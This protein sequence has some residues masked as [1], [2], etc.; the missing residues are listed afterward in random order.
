MCLSNSPQIAHINSVLSDKNLDLKQLFD[1]DSNSVLNECNYILPEDVHEISNGLDLKIMH[2]N[3]R[4][5]PNKMDEF[6]MLIE[7]A[8]SNNSH[9]DIVLVCETFIN[10]FN[11]HQCAL[12]NYVLFEKHRS[13]KKGGGVAI[14]VHDSIRVEERNDLDIFIEGQIESLFVEIELNGKQMTVGELYRVPGSDLSSFFVSYDSLLRTLNNENKM[15]IIGTDQNL[16]FL[17][18]DTH[19]NT[20]K[21]LNMNL[22]SGLVPM[23]TR[24]TRITHS[25]C[26]LIDNIYTNVKLSVKPFVLISDISD[27]LPCCLFVARKKNDKTLIESRK[28]NDSNIANIKCSLSKINWDILDSLDIDDSYDFF[29][30]T[31]NKSL[32]ENAPKVI[33]KLSQKYII[34][35]PWMTSGLLKS[36]KIC[37]RLYKQQIG[38]NNSDDKRAKYLVYRNKYN[39]LKRIARKN[40]YSEQIRN[41]K[42]DSKKLWS[43]F[44]KV[45]GKTKNKLDLPSKIKDKN[46]IIISGSINIANEFCD[47]FSNIGSNLSSKIAAPNVSYNEY[48]DD[49]W[50]GNAFFLSPTDEQE[51]A[52][53]I[54]S[55]K[56]KNSSGYDGI[57]NVLIKKLTSEICYPLAIIFNKS[58][59]EGK[60]P[61][62]MKVADVLP[63]FKSK[64]KSVC[65]NYR[66]IS[67]LPVVSKVLERI[68][69]KRLYYF[70]Q[71]EHLLYN[72]QYGFRNKHS[73]INA[74]MEFVGKVLNGF[75]NEQY[76]LSVFLDLSK[77]FDTID[78]NILLNKLDRYGIRGQANNWFKSYLSER[79][80]QV[81]Y[82]D[83]VRSRLMTVNC[84][85]P[86]GSV[87]GP[88]LFIIYTNDIYKSVVGS[89]CIL[90]AD[91][92]TMFSIHK[93]I[94]TLVKIITKDMNILIDWFKANKLSLNL[95]K[96]N[97]MLFKPKHKKERN[98]VLNFDSETLRS[99]SNTK[100][101]GLIIDENLTWSNHIKN[102]HLKL[103]KGLYT[104]RS[105]RKSLPNWTKRIL[106]M[107]FINSHINYGLSLWGPMALSSD[108]KK[109]EKQQKKALR[110]I[111]TATYNSHT[112]PIFKKYK[113]LKLKDMINLELGKFMYG[114]EKGTL[115]LPLQNLFK[116]NVDIH[117]YN[118]RGKMS[119]NTQQHK[120]TIYNKSFLAR[121]PALWSQFQ[122][123]QKM[124]P[125][126]N[127][128][129]RNFKKNCIS[130]Y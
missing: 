125:S 46:S 98:V 72:S 127:S 116:R 27:H 15:V 39:S 108:I 44:N 56:N 126:V 52:K 84:G 104:L 41:F 36:S 45:I 114:F 68:I 1:D 96:T 11:I 77:A 21:F 31:L 34:R 49:V 107:S 91:D 100:F 23:I 120:S 24:P 119:V 97:C 9:Y 110:H 63:V 53:I 92:T 113:I 35:E 94:D 85:V 57:S 109:L 26:T 37:D 19:K 13:S 43:I 78:H 42:N 8:N 79:Q 61:R 73:T 50:S 32:D 75:E 28:L 30:N 74:V 65:T 29:M 130:S 76:T 123:D 70:L 18:I 93:D 121:G 55:L 124:C 7:K 54:L 66:P 59:L 3:I 38:C 47:F 10:D 5:L 87:L 82:T 40:Y 48:M 112:D 62:A 80:Q 14:Y 81:K 88:L 103:A 83:G 17:K 99:V 69:Y 60:F 67:L 105:V 20:A 90:F 33:L 25:S 2:I 4:S 89:H 101:L 128:F 111:D 71:K 117:H 95:G 102:V 16:D 6:K 64:D 51:I 115:P 106:Y 58:I 129:V 122:N 22:D 118:T 86:Q 12:E